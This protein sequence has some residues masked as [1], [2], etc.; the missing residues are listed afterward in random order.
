MQSCFENEVVRAS[1]GSGKTFELSERYL[2]LIL[3]GEPVESILATTFTR[4]AAGEIQDRI[5]LRLG[6]GAATPE[7][8]SNL[9]NELCVSNNPLKAER[10]AA[11]IQVSG[12][13]KENAQEKFKT[14]LAHLVHELNRL[15]VCTLDSFFMQIAGGYAF[16]IGLPPNWGIIEETDNKHL[17][18]GALLASF[19]Q[20]TNKNKSDA[21]VLSDLLFKGESVRTVEKQIGDIIDDWT[22]IYNEASRVEDAV[23]WFSYESSMSADQ[24]T[25]FQCEAL[26]KLE[27]LRTTIPPT[28]S[29][30]P[31][32]F[33][34]S[35]LQN[36]INL[37]SSNNKY[38]WQKI[39]ESTLV[40][41]INQKLDKF[42]RTTIPSDWREVFGN[43]GKT[44]LKETL[45]NISQR[46]F[47]IHFTL[48]TV[49]HYLENDKKANGAYRFD[50][51]TRNL[52]EH[53]LANELERI[54]YRI[55]SKTNHILLDEFQDASLDQWAIIKPFAERVVRPRP[56]D[57]SRTVGSFYCVGDVKQAI[58]GWRGGK[59]EIFDQIEKKDLPGVKARSLPTNWRSSPRIIEVVNQLFENLQSN[60]AFTLKDSKEQEYA[61]EIAAIHA[62]RD[63]WA[64]EEHKTAPKNAGKPGYWSLEQAPRIKDGMIPRDLTP[65]DPTTI[66][67]NDKFEWESVYSSGNLDVDDNENEEDA[68]SS[69]EGEIKQV[70]ATVR[71]AV[72]RIAQLRVEYPNASIGVL[73]RT[74][75]RIGQIVAGLKEK[76]KDTDV[77][78][79]E[80]GGV[81]LSESPAV[82]AVLSV[83]KFGAHPGD[84]VSSFHIANI[85]PLFRYF[86]SE[87]DQENEQEFESKEISPRQSSRIRQLIE[88]QG[89]GK[90]VSDISELLKPICDKKRDIERLDKLVEFAYSFETSTRDFTLDRFIEGAL[91]RKVESPSKSQ[92]RV[93]SLHKSKGLEFD[94]V[95][96][97]ELDASID[98]MM[99]NK[100]LVHRADP[101][102][103]PDRIISQPSTEL[104]I[105]VM[106]ND[107]DS[108]IKSLAEWMEEAYKTTLQTVIQE[109][110]CL[111]Y[112]G[113]TRP[114]H[115][116]VAIVDPVKGTT[117]K[118]TGERVPPKE[119][120][121][122]LTFSAIL[123]EGLMKPEI[124]ETQKD[125]KR[126]GDSRPQLLF[127]Y[128]E[129]D[130]YSSLSESGAEA[131][132]VEL[133]RPLLSSQTDEERDQYFEPTR[134]LYARSTPT[135]GRATYAWTPD[136]SFQDGT[137]LHACFESIGWLEDGVPG[138]SQTARIVGRTVS[139]SQERER[140]TKRFTQIINHDFTKA[141]LS[142][143]TYEKSFSEF[144]NRFGGVISAAANTNGLSAPNW[145]VFRERP[146]SFTDKKDNREQLVR[147]T[148]DRLVLLYDGDRLVA[149]DV[150]DFK[151]D[152]YK[153]SAETFEEYRSQLGEYRKAIEQQFKLPREKITLRLAFVAE[154]GWPDGERTY[155]VDQR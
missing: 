128:G 91:E 2:K 1:A 139:N 132:S 51:L 90:T 8:A 35:A 61:L 108:E 59:A 29:K 126:F 82:Q 127:E 20:A 144:A 117:D 141:L 84:T 96:L 7:G 24:L 54:A 155:V 94:I 146:F 26:D 43:I 98:S 11:F 41:N 42:G 28:S 133:N 23:P 81:L 134:L 32:S 103:P 36:A 131:E 71:Y 68:S 10:N 100:I 22:S 37:L 79:S 151:T 74:N 150:I 31:N 147:G 47:A 110:L 111:L 142:R 5:L 18:Y 102:A 69:D 122:S 3:C 60:K 138:S 149:A 86:T 45:S 119:P 64:F 16:E 19:S 12:L 93:M 129:K 137:A 153:P 121:K 55:S 38:K 52:V 83:L 63:N 17:I 76:F 4:K 99:K 67:E 33:Y 118:K 77:E 135:G 109:A 48:K 112:V 124:W 136:K 66:G 106:G 73:P 72:S 15:R 6:K 101:T 97:P 75:A 152:A 143:S 50:D 30:K 154:Q 34:T 92:I 27:G 116:L 25:Q 53:S 57:P 40:K 88:T 21:I 13:N 120:G 65:I 80:E 78:I 14:S 87:P 49:S 123:K 46:L 56:E 105:A 39:L 107:D 104:R 44:V 62:A 70:V 115:M 9:Y 148:I 95:V 145:K 113:I 58:Y 85:P 89:L 125:V 140:I 114:V 130:W